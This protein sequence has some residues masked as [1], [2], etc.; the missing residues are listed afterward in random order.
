M[1]LLEP[2]S[3]YRSL[4][5]VALLFCRHSCSGVD[6]FTLH[7]VIDPLPDV[8]GRAEIHSPPWGGGQSSGSSVFSLARNVAPLRR[9]CKKALATATS[10]GGHQSMRALPRSS[11]GSNGLV[12]AL[13][14]RSIN[15]FVAEPRVHHCLLWEQK[16]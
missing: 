12:S 2:A 5:V 16:L 3:A 1:D 8:W 13:S 10:G 11:A 15:H 9:R 14:R 6:L 7:C 4:A